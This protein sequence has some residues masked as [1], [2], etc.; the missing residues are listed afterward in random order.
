M[1][2][3]EIKRVSF[4]VHWFSLSSAMLSTDMLITIS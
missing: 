1:D 3:A 2:Q 4:R